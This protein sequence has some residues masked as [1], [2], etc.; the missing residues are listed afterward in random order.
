MALPNGYKEL[1]YIESTGTQYIDTGFTPNA[2]T[3]V[4]VTYENPSATSGVCVIGSD[5]TWK[6]NGFA[7]YSHL[8]DL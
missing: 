2:N 4:E 5:T 6:S 3:R 7:L 8:F 1:E